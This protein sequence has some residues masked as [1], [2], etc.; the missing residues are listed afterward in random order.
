MGREP[1]QLQLAIALPIIPTEP[2]VRPHGLKATVAMGPQRSLCGNNTMELSLTNFI[3]VFKWASHWSLSTSRWT[4]SVQPCPISIR[5]VLILSCHLSVSLLAFPPKSYMQPSSPP[6][7]LQFWLH[8][9]KSTTW[10]SSLSS[11]LQPPIVSCLFC[12]NVPK[13]I[14]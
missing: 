3:T 8:L 14:K 2:S 12:S 7:L 11:F 6:V 4:Q 5:S 9:V 1:L 13:Y 10:S